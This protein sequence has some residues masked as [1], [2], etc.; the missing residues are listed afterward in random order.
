MP[1]SSELYMHELDRK[2]FNALNAFPKLVRLKELYLANTN[3]KAEKIEL[4]STAIR[5]SEN[6][7]PEIYRLLPPIC[8]NLGI[9]LPELY[10]VKSKELNAFT[11]GTT[12]PMI[13]ITSRFFSYFNKER[14]EAYLFSDSSGR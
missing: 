12:Y 13:C 11:M 2:A 9:P 1:Y 14:A 8:E 7:F 10:Y 4:M 6:Q 3:E 5:I